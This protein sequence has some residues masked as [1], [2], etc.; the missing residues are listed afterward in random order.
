MVDLGAPRGIQRPFGG[1]FLSSIG[2]LRLEDQIGFDQWLQIPF[3]AKTCADVE[4]VA[5]PTPE[6][7]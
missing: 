6:E 5:G 7:T 1:D 3:G 2:I 4:L